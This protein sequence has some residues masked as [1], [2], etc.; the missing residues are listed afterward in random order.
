MNQMV[1]SWNRCQ[2]REKYKGPDAVSIDGERFLLEEKEMEDLTMSSYNFDSLIRQIKQN[3]LDQ[4][5]GLKTITY[6][7]LKRLNLKRDKSKAVAGIPKGSDQS[8]LQ[9]FAVWC[10]KLTNE[11]S[12]VKAVAQLV[13]ID[14]TAAIRV[15]G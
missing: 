2:E 1:R 9:S 3:S 6:S 12:H 7:T 15:A 5:K 10:Q 8:N 14:A 11:K 13:A 4:V